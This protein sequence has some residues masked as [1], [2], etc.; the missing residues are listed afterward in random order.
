MH[1][2]MM[3]PKA[4]T[5]IALATAMLVGA[6]MTAVSPATATAQLPAICAQY[7]NLP[8]CLGPDRDED[9]DDDDDDRLGSPTASA[10]TGGAGGEL[11]FTG[12]P[13]NPLILLFLSMLALGLAS[14]SYLAI[15]ERMRTR[16][17]HDRFS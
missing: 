3:S 4:L 11:P 9:D 7:P 10:P 6:F 8:Q 14:R 16:E 2:K 13:L 5:L 1:L 15:R 17:A 12:Y